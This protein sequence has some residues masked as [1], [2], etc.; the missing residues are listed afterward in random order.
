[1]RSLFSTVTKKMIAGYLVILVFNLSAIGFALTRLHQQTRDTEQLVNVEFRMFE[2]VR[3]LQQNLLAQENIE[4][5]LLILKDSTLSELRLNRNEE[6]TR[7]A[8]ALNRPPIAEPVKVLIKLVETYRQAE[9]DLSDALFWESWGRAKEISNEKTIPVRIEILK[10]LAEFRQKKQ[11]EINTGLGR[12][13]ERTN[14]AFQMTALLTLIGICLSAPVSLTVMFSIHRSVKALKAATQKISAG[15]FD[16]RPELSGG[17]EFSQLANDFRMMGEKLQELEQ[18]RLDANPLTQLPGNLAIDREVD[19]RITSKEPFSHLYIDL[20]NFKAY[21]DRYGYKAGSDVL[22]M[23]GELLKNVVME[24]G[25]EADLVGHIGGDDYVILTNLESAELL[26]QEIVQRFDETIPSYYNQQDREAKSFTGKDR[27]GVK[28]TFPLMTISIAVV[29][30]T[31]Y[32][33]P[34]RLAISQDCARLKEY[35]KI[36]QGSNYMLEKRKH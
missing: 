6:F 20:D 1:M 10:Y 14:D 3:D 7:L 34:S 22:A 27:Y 28:R 30:S 18:L 4:K 11:Q 35:L 8:L 31:H 36:Q 21:S 2:L 9:N 5:Q 16:Y 26:A 25:S 15:S 24:K 32:E 19:R 17:D 29:P 23:V 33:Y 12:L 13:S